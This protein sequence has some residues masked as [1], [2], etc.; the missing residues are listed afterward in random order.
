MIAGVLLRAGIGRR[1]RRRR[2]IIVA[3]PAV[4]VIGAGRKVSVL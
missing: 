1:A 2:N 3:T 4:R